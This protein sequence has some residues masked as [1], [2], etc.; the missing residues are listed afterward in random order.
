MDFEEKIIVV[1]EGQSPMRIDKFLANKLFQ[2]TRNKIQN[3]IKNE[4]VT[5]NGSL[6]KAN[7]KVQPSDEII[8]QIPLNAEYDGVV[9]PEDIPLD[10]VYEDE[11]LLVIDKAP[12]LVVHPG[13]GNYTGTL[14]N[15]LVHHLQNSDL[16]VLPGNSMDRPGL[17]HRIDKDTSGLLVIAKTEAVLSHL[18]AQFHEHSVQRRYQAIV[19][20]QPDPADGTI[21]API[22]RHLKNRTMYA[23]YDQEEAELAKNAVT[24]YST[25]QSYYYV[26]LIECRLE[27]GRTHQIRVHMDSIGHTIFND[28]KYGG[29]QILKGTVFNKYKQFVENCIKICPRQA[30]HAKSLGFVHPVTEKPMYFESPLPADMQ[31]VLDKWDKYVE[32]RI[33][34]FEN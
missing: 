9:L 5:V 31:G 26:S 30:L 17:V 29:D 16:P 4:W 15:A 27:T 23:T 34:K 21:D 12:G 14:V 8:M 32:D 33:D 10:V 24:H 20:G 1:D 2:V 28:E 25:I 3:G 7:Y 11:Y 13:T 19:W 18:A 22:G 6:V